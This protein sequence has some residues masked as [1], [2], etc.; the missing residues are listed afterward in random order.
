MKVTIEYYQ[1]RA[2]PP[3]SCDGTP[4][5]IATKVKEMEL[6]ARVRDLTHVALKRIGDLDLQKAEAKPRPAAPRSP[7]R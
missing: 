6:P 3:I 4:D 5:E 7:R 2:A 1:S